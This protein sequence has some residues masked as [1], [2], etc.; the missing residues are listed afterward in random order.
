MARVRFLTMMVTAHLLA[1]CVAPVPTRPEPDYQPVM[2]ASEPQPAKTLGSI[3]GDSQFDN[4]FVDRRAFRVGDVVTVRLEERTSSSK[5][6]ETSVK[7]E[8]SNELL[9]PQVLGES[10]GAT[11][12]Q[13][14]S[15]LD[16]KNDFKGTAGS[17][18]S[19]SLDGTLTVIVAE[20]YPN[21]LMRV[22]GEKWLHLNQGEEYL[23]L[24]G[25]LR[26]EDIGDDNSVSSA[27]LADARFSYSGTGDLANSNAP[28]WLSRFFLSP[29]FPF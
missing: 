21:G 6:A 29:K 28:G 16:S 18:Q 1:G 3:Y 15:A 25:L 7:K 24:S 12:G 13:S 10:F 5:S 17:D 26:S 23:R 4:L 8:A 22:R 19:N 9:N 11:L 14:M 27:R 20:V 2:P